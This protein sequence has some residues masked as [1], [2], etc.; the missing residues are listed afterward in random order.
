MDGIDLKSSFISH[1]L[2]VYTKATDFGVLK[3]LT[4]QDVEA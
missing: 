4:I 1:G 3:V 2:F